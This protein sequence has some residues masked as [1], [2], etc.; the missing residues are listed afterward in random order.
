MGS[1]KKVVRPAAKREL[2]RSLGKEFSLSERRAC[3]ITGAHRSTVRH[4]PK[5][6]CDVDTL[7]KIRSIAVN[8]PRY[9]CPRVHTMLRR[10]GIIINHKRTERIYYENGLQLKKRPP[11]RKRRRP[12][13]EVPRPCGPNRK[14]S[15]DFVHDNLADGRPI[16]ILTVIDEYTRE[17][18]GM[19]VD[20]SLS[21]ERLVATMNKIG[22]GRPLPSNIGADQGP[23]FISNAFLR[24]AQSKGVTVS[25][26]QPGNKNENAFVESFNGRLRDECLNMHWF[27]SLREARAEVE[28]WRHHYNNHRPH[29]SLGGLTPSEFAAS[30]KCALVA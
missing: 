13:S 19:E 12:V 3:R 9:G 21:S 25:Y 11:K 5:D 30:G 8:N 20:T 15:L 29:S 6:R 7:A 18:V 17:C 14:W 23:E 27:L 28:E 22:M 10:Q 24:W 1:R 16:R 2:T 4:Q 26:C